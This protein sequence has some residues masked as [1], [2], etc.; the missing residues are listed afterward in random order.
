MRSADHLTLPDQKKQK[1]AYVQIVV[2]VLQLG[3]LG[4]GLSNCPV[5]ALQS[6]FPRACVITF[7]F[8]SRMV[9]QSPFT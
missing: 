1:K 3:G 4:G 2:Q 6:T 5:A 7:L 8:F 9:H